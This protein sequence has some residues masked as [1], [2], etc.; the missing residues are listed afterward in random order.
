MTDN[1]IQIA[2]W[3]AEFE[4]LRP[5]LDKKENRIYASKK[6]FKFF[7]FIYMS[8]YLTLKPA[9]FH[10]ESW[11]GAFKDRTCQ[12]WFR[13]S[14]KSVI[15]SVCY[16]LWKLLLNPDDL[17]LKWQ[18]YDIFCISKTSS[19]VEKWIRI[20]K[21]E[22]TENTRIIADFAPDQGEIW[23][24]DEYELNGRGRVRAIGVGGQFRGEHPTDAILDDI[25]DREEAKSESNRDKLREWFYGD[26]MGALRME[27]G[28]DVRVKIIG[29]CVHPLGIMQELYKLDWW[30]STKYAL[31]KQDGVTPSWP[32]YM[33]VDKIEDLRSKIPEPI[34]MAEYMNSP[35]ISENPTFERK[36]FMKYEP[37]ML[38][39]PDGKKLNYR[40]M[41]L[42]TSHD[43]AISTRDG[44]DYSAVTQW[45]VVMGKEPKI[46]LLECRRGHW[47]APKQITELL[48]LYEKYPGTAQLIETVGGFEALYQEYKDRLERERLNIKIHSIKPHKDKGIRANSV[49]HLFERG[50]V[51]FDHTDRMQNLLM[52]EL[53]LFDYSTRKHGRDDWVDSTTQALNY[54]DELI[55]RYTKK[56]NRKKGFSLLWEP[57]NPIYGGGRIS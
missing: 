6:S 25:E 34:Y 19:L 18:K 30:E 26:F 11:E 35:I 16:P 56:A 38:R 31:Y 49:I 23:R 46:Y 48:S 15:W 22:L 5:E 3:D 52:D 9:D 2:A 50:M 28:K 24:N 29:N 12:L 7:L 39:G 37:G 4:A 43:P 17:D 53:V 54:I 13:G 1:A 10:L 32:E 51:Y 57:T 14:G 20:Q 55:R 21:R 44:A 8:H 45:G 47:S 42:I 40:D 36:H 41:L 27:E 33:D